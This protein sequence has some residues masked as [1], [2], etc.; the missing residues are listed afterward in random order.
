MKN[1]KEHSMHFTESSLISTEISEKP[2]DDKSPLAAEEV[3]SCSQGPR[4][5][6][7]IGTLSK[8]SEF[9]YNKC[10]SFFLLKSH[11]SIT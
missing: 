3:P 5:A 8:D 1:S 10:E 9:S 7:E 4:D 6:S 11:D 2:L